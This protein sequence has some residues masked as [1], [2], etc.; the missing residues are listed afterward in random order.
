MVFFPRPVNF[1]GD[2]SDQKYCLFC[3]AANS[4]EVVLCAK[5]GERFRTVSAGSAPLF[6]PSRY[7]SGK[8]LHA[9]S[10]F[11]RRYVVYGV[12]AFLILFVVMS[13]AFPSS[14]SLAGPSSSPPARPPVPAAQAQAAASPIEQAIV[15]PDLATQTT[16]GEA[17]V[18]TIGQSELDLTNNG[19]QAAGPAMTETLA[20]NGQPTYSDNAFGVQPMNNR[21]FSGNAWTSARD[22]TDASAQSTSSVTWLEGNSYFG[23][24]TAPQH[25]TGS[26]IADGSALFA[27]VGV[28]HGSLL[29]YVQ[30]LLAK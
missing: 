6:A 16:G 15:S 12:A 18:S 24:C 29:W 11:K 21:G 22:V 9:A 19:V 28:F 10:R 13:A 5:C 27:R 3:G 17:S 25:M 4:R 20:L 8:P 26:E 23:S 30:T 1:W 7:K 2:M 14:S